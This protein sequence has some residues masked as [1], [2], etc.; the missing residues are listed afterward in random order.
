MINQIIARVRLTN[1]G[2]PRV[3]LLLSA[4][5]RIRRLRFDVDENF[6]YLDM[7]G[8]C[9]AQKADTLWLCERLV[10]AGFLNFNIRQSW[11]S[12]RHSH[13]ETPALV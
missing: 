2:D 13:H 11:Q 3:E 9:D 10:K 8:E 1:G 12:D 6:Q 5:P 7:C 4:E